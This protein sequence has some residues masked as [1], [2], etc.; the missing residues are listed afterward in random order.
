MEESLPEQNGRT[1]PAN[2][3][4]KEEEEMEVTMTSR[5]ESLTVPPVSAVTSS[6]TQ[7]PPE[8]SSD[9]ALPVAP[10]CE[11]EDSDR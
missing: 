10:A 2:T 3:T 1:T 11:E 5:L 9:A 6:D 7:T 8:E 4:D